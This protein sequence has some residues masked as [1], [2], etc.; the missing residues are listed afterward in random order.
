MKTKALLHEK[1]WFPGI[2]RMVKATIDHCISCQAT[3]RPNPPEPLQMSEI[4]QG[5]WQKVH[6]D[7]YGPLPS[8][9]YLLVVIDR[10]SRYPEVEI[11]RSTKASSVIPKFDKIFSTHGI[12][13]SMTTD[14]GPP[15]N[16]AEYSRYLEVLGID[17]SHST[18]MWPE[19]EHFN[20]PLNCVLTTATLEGKVWQQEL[21]RFL[22]QYCTTPPPCHNKS[23]TH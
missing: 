18:P 8:G 23:S 12:P 7:F 6:A 2:D 16:S 9:E 20:Q 19:V 5:P 13:I 1:V 15:F 11:V 4:P 21:N 3:G 22:L 10:Y 17:E 14:N